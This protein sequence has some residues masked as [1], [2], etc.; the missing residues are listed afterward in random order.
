MQIK[1]TASS[2]VLLELDGVQILLDGVSQ[3]VGS[4]LPTP[5]HI[6][7]ALLEELPDGLAFTHSHPDHYEASFASAYLQKAA[8]PVIGPADIPLCRE[9]TVQIGTVRVTPVESR[10]IGKT[11]GVR[12]CS[13]VVE[14]SRC[15]WFMGDAAP[16]QWRRRMDLPRPDVLLIPFAYAIG[17]SW[18]QT[19]ALGASQIVLL[20]LPDPGNDPYALW[21]GVRQTVGADWN[22][23]YIPKMGEHITL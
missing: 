9:E 3:Q 17:S 19:K 10:H 6:R 20:H 18:E 4:Y 13:F 16:A 7:Q 11:G 8:G 15:L 2:G 14:G 12:H 21:D 22:S 5:P 23:L 1:R